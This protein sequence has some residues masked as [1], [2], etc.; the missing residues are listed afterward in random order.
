MGPPDVRLD[1]RLSVSQGAHEETGPLFP[2][3]KSRVQRYPESQ[4]DVYIYGPRTSSSGTLCVGHPVMRSAL[5]LWSTP[6]I[7]WD[8]PGPTVDLSAEVT[9]DSKSHYGE[10]EDSWTTPGRVLGRWNGT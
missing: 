7:G 2:P 3:T 9:S 6:N 1:V 4:E 5:P 8:V 10:G